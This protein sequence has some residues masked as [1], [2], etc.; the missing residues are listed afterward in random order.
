MLGDDLDLVVNEWELQGT[1]ALTRPDA[2]LE[3]LTKVRLAVD[4]VR[5]PDLP[6]IPAP[7]PAGF[8]LLASAL[9]VV[10]WIEPRATTRRRAWLVPRSSNG[11]R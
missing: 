8:L 7:E 4:L 2:A 5:H 6:F 9:G 11:I 1:V 3:D 10:A